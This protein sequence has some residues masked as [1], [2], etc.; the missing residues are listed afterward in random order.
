[1]KQK[2]TYGAI[3]N[4]RLVAAL[5]IVAIHTAPLKSF[6]ATADYL[7]TYC[8]GRI[9]VPFFFL[10]T[11]FF[12]LAPYERALFQTPAAGR[13]AFRKTG[14]FLK[15]TTALY[16]AATLLYLPVKV[17]SKQLGGIW[18]S[19]QEILFD[20]TFY[21]LWYLPAVL[22][23]CL[24]V[25]ALMRTCSPSTGFLVTIV[26]YLIGVFGDSYYHLVEHIP[27]IGACYQGIFAIS[28]YTRNGIFFAPVFLWIGAVIANQNIRMPA[29]HAAAGFLVSLA[30]MLAEGYLTYQME[31]QKH[32]S[33]YLFL[34]PVMCF[35]F[36]LLL[37]V[38]GKAFWAARDVSMY[39]YIIHP[40]CI[41]LVRGA[42]SVTNMKKL[43]VGQS[44]VHYIAVSMLS[45]GLSLMLAYGMRRLKSNAR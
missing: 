22:L 29:S 35:L 13:K 16:A 41:I 1:M 21:H 37:S 19:I 14:T 7:V 15:R 44:L 6:N 27:V 11:G 30:G 39:I 26:L 28:A 12:V 10:V 3:D 32:N 43:L 4:F 40:L 17:Y 33:M 45:V 18:E 20:G 9:A 25:M 36:L 24:F 38:K 23:G 5:L 2:K 34:L 31:W 42:A 8:F